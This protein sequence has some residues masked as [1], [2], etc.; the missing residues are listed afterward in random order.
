MQH[1]EN[2]K[3]YKGLV[4]NEGVQ[5]LP[6][7]NPYAT[8]RRQKRELTAEEYVDGILRGDITLLGQAVTS[9]ESSLPKEIA[10]GRFEK[11][12]F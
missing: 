3:Q 2:D 10:V 8:F 11:L 6:Q 9:I 7:V 12:S 1:P 4:V 5:N